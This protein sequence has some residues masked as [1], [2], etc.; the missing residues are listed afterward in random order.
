MV[1]SGNVLL[2]FSAWRRIQER[3]AGPFKDKLAVFLA[4]SLKENRIRN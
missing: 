3:V 2:L 1:E 4:L